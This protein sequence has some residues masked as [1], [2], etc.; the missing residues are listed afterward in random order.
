MLQ[1]SRNYP[2]ALYLQI[3]A[4][5]EQD[6]RSD[7]IKQ[8][9][10]IGTQLEL[11]KRFEVSKVTI[12]KA[13]EALENKGLVV[14]IHGKGTFVRP[15]KVEQA[16]NHLKGLTDIINESGFDS[17]VKITTM[18][19]VLDEEVFLSDIESADKSKY[20]YI[21]RLHFIKEKPIALAKI[22]LP[23]EIGKQLD[24][25]ELESQTLYSLL[26]Q[27]LG[28]TI[29]EATQFIEACPADDKLVDTLEVQKGTPLL[30]IERD[31][32]NNANKLIEKIVFYYRH[33]AFSL[34]I[35]L[36]RPDK[37]SIWP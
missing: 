14:T 10:R 33:D 20:L 7:K 2:V 13:I 36:N 23:Y 30:K 5:L 29:G 15:E 3:A 12:R 9:E 19:M 24:K 1:I 6:I 32:L 35:K 11:E 28:I 4:A 21:E 37:D 25:K 17:Y 31:T 34:K 22:Y 27:K 16:L 8:G 18:K 26:E